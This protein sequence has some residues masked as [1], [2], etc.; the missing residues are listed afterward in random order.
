MQ[1][2]LALSNLFSQLESFSS[3]EVSAHHT[4][5]DTVLAGFGGASGFLAVGRGSGWVCTASSRGRAREL[6]LDDKIDGYLAGAQVRW[7]ET[8]FCGVHR[9]DHGTIALRVDRSDPSQGGFTE[10][11]AVPLKLALDLLGAYQTLHHSRRRE[12]TAQEATKQILDLVRRLGES[13]PGEGFFQ[14]L[15]LSALAVVSEAD[16]GSVAVLDQGYWRF[17]ACVGHDE[18]SLRPLKIPEGAFG[19][20]SEVVVVDDL[21]TRS[22]V[23]PSEVRAVLRARSRLVAR[24]MIVGMD[25]GPDYRINLSLDVRKGSKKQ[26]AE[27]SKLAMD[28]FVHLATSFVRLRLQRELLERSYRNFTDKLALLAEVHDKSTAMHNVRVSAVSGFLAEKMGLSSDEVKGIR[29][30]AMVHDIGKLFLAPELLNKTGPLTASEKEKLKEHTLFAEKLLDDPYFAMDQKIALYHHERYDGR[31][32]PRGLRGDEIPIQAQIVS[33][34]DVY[35]ALRTT[36]SYKGAFS[37]VE[38]LRRMRFGDE[39]LE[40][41]GFN[42]QILAILEAHWET[43][44][45]LC[46]RTQ[47]PWEAL[48]AESHPFVVPVR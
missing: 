15:L 44:E 6:E 27:G 45:A 43:I 9:G 41:G 37:P 28:R 39:R 4:I 2:I 47:G 46:H 36:R 12:Q 24:S 23:L 31:G 8:T 32:Y 1:G 16:Y 35:D 13:G 3:D 33:A 40:A 22:K 11:D 26:F 38:A 14:E 17:V 18:E 20:F 5:L 7:T 19:S 42:P 29:Q 25:V 21:L 30:G 10:A 48:S 34:A